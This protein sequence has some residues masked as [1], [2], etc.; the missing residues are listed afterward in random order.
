MITYNELIEKCHSEKKNDHNFYYYHRFLSLP[1]TIIFYKFKVKPD[2][3]SISMILLSFASFV[4]MIFE[5]DILFWLGVF[6]SFLA[7]LFDKVDGDLARLYKV[8]NI[9]GAVY[10]FVYHRVSIFLFY[11]GIGMHFSYQNEYMVV[12]A[13]SCGFIANYIEEMQLLPFRIFAHK[14]L[15]KNEN[16]IENKTKIKT[17]EPGYIKALKMFRT[18][19][20]L[21]YFIIIC[22]LLEC[23]LNNIVF[24]FTS[25]A[26]SSMVIYSIFQIYSSMKYSFD[27]D[28]NTLILITKKHKK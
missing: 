9:K 14:Y 5:N 6:V 13:A 3:I 16:I 17:K 12:I 8:D 20:L 18:Q 25:F 1:L 26:L 28:V 11:L 19:L 23:Y 15:L 2:V 4:L 7:F 24:Y 10:D 27:E 22:V 21:Y